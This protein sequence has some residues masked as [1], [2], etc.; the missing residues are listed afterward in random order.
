MA[1]RVF[2]SARAALEVTR[3]TDLTPTRL[4]YGEEFTHEQDRMTIR[5]A[6][7]RN[8]YEGFFQAS[9][10]VETNTF[11]IS[12]RMSY[13]DLI[14]YAN[15]FVAPLA[16]GTGAGADK[17]WAFA[18]SLTSDNVKTATVQLGYADTIAT[19]PGV[20]LNYCLGN[21]FNLH[22]EKNDDG[23][24]TFSS[25]FF[26][27]SAATQITAFTGSLSDRVVTPMS[28]NNTLVYLDA[29]TIGT[30]LDNNVTAVD[31]TL[32]LG[33][34]AFY[35]LDG[36]TAANA[37]YRPNHRTWTC[38]ITRR[39]A[40]DNEWDRYVDKAKRKIRI[41]TVGP[42]L[43]ST[44]YSAL[45]DLYGVYTGR[46][47]ADIDGIIT[48]ELTFEPLYDTTAA[49]SFYMAVTNATASIT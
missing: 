39:Y 21:T 17:L 42:V 5:P 29:T 18:P 24:V 14:W 23:A 3:G 46:T 6:E 20:R 8:S 33:P 16:S 26:I 32:N 10:G 22:W 19:A 40:N 4:I 9:A 34:V 25:D 35:A 13:D 43:G 36:T 28:S 11:G 47:W 44:N 1:L 2:T 7:L 38:T 48:E 31:W 27:G 12:G 41:N 37:I 15:L 30:T 49:G 45:L